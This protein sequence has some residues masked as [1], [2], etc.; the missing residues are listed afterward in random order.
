MRLGR[1]AGLGV[2]AAIAAG[3]AQGAPEKQAVTGPVA[4]YWISAATNSGMAKSR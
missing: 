1:T 2:L 4:V 3:A